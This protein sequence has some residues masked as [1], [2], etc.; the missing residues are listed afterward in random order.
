[1]HDTG[2]VS[3]CQ[4]LAGLLENRHGA[5]CG[6]EALALDDLAQRASLDVLHGEEV[7]AVL[8]ADGVHLHD[9]RVAELRR[10]LGLTFET[11]DELRLLRTGGSR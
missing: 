6:E 1:M 5:R 9:I 8:L 2:V 4:C 3:H 10:G 11:L 7:D